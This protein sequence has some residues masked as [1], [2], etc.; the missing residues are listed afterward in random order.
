MHFP[1]TN[2][3]LMTVA[4]PGYNTLG[5]RILSARRFPVAIAHRQME[6]SPGLAYPFL[7]ANFAE[8]QLHVTT[9]LYMFIYIFGGRSQR[10]IFSPLVVEIEETRGISRS[11]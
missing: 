10:S 7:S 3:F 11:K 2:K 5:N 4:T 8:G 6:I 1:A 9:K